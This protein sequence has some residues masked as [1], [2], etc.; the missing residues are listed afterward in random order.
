[1]KKNDFILK[2]K[3]PFNFEGKEYN[4]VDLSGITSLCAEDLCEAQ[5]MLSDMGI[6]SSVVEMNYMYNFLLAAKATC[7]P[8]EFF[9]RMPG[10]YAAQLKTK[11]SGY[12]LAD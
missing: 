5:D 3:E 1:M 12:F 4:E 7:L 10:K 11:V 8:I 2:F 6:V 9:K